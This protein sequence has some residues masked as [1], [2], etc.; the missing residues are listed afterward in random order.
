MKSSICC[1]TMFSIVGHPA[2]ICIEGETIM[3]KKILGLLL[4]LCL[5][6]G[7]LPIMAIAETTSA[8]VTLWGTAVTV[9]TDDATTDVPAAY[10]WTNGAE[11]ATPVAATAADAWNYAFT[12][13]D[14]VP[15][16]TLKNA[17]F[18]SASTFLSATFDGKL[19]VKFE[20]TNNL[21]VTGKY[22]IYY[23]SST[24]SAGKGNLFI[25]GAADATLNITGG[26]SGG[27]FLSTGKKE[28]VTISGG[29]INMEKTKAGGVNPL[30][31]MPYSKTLVENCT[32]NV[33]M[34]D[35]VGGKHPAVVM[36]YNTYGVTINN[37]NVTIETNAH[38]GF[39]MGVFQSNMTGIIYDA[40]LTITGDSNIK[41]INNANSTSSYAYNGVGLYAKTVTVKGGNLEVE[42]KK[43]AVYTT[44]EAGPNLS[45]YAGTCEMYTEKGG[46]AVTAYTATP[47]F[48]VKFVS[49]AIPST[50][51]TAPA[52]T[53]VTTPTTPSIPTAPTTPDP[54]PQ[55][56]TLKIYGDSYT[57]T[58]YDTPIYLVNGT[59]NGFYKGSDDTA[60]TKAY[61][62]QVKTG[63]TADNYNAK[64]VWNTGD[65]G[66]TLYLRDFIVDEYVEGCGWR[67]GAENLKNA[68]AV[69]G[70]HTGTAAPL[71]IVIERGECYMR[72]YDGLHYQN[73]LTIES[74]GDA[75]LTLYTLRTGILPTNV[76]AGYANTNT[77]LSGCKL[78]LDANLTV[79]MGSW[80]NMDN[81]SHVI[82]TI[83]ADLIINGGKIITENRGLSGKSCRGIGVVNSGNLYVNGGYVYSE[84]YNATNNT[85]AA[86]EAA[87]NIYI[88]G[89][90]VDVYSANQSGLRGTNIYITGGTVKARV[91]LAP[92][93]VGAETGEISFTGGVIDA[94]GAY[95]FRYN[96]DTKSQATKEPVLGT[97]L[98]G[99]VG[100]NPYVVEAYTDTFKKYVKIGYT[101][102]EKNEVPVPTPG[103]DILL[104][105]NVSFGTLKLDL[106]KYDEP[107]YTINSSIETTDAAGNPFTRWVQTTK[108]ANADNWNAMFI[109]KSTDAEPTLYLRGFKLDD[110]NN[111]ASKFAVNPNN[112]NGYYQT[113]SITTGSD[114]PLTI[115]LTG[116]DSMIECQ[117]G[118]TYN[119]NLT[120]KSEGNTKLTM[121]NQSS[122]ISPNKAAGFTL[123]IDANLVITIR[124]FYNTE[125][126]SGC[127]MNYQGDIII[128]GG[129]I[130]CNAK[131]QNKK[132]VN[133]IVAR[134][135]GNI[136]ING[137]TIT[138][139][140]TV[141]QSHANGVIQTKDKLIINGGT[142]NVQPNSAVGLHA[143]KAIE[144]NG[145]TINVISP[146]YAITTGTTA[147]PGEVI[148]NGGTL[149]VLAERCFYGNTKITIGDGV[150]AY[151]GPNEKDAELYDGSDTKLIQ[152]PWWLSTD[153]DSITIETKPATTIPTIPSF[154]QP[155]T[156]ATT[157]TGSATEPTGGATT[158]PTG[159]T[160]TT[161]T[162][163]ASTGNGEDGGDSTTTILIVA[164]IAVVVLCAGAVTFIIIKRKKA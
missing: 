12:I 17:N 118:I 70:F 7:L 150:R 158:E 38:T 92:L 72:T 6:V 106:K 69:A 108:G 146:W 115:I 102:I 97:G 131:D 81:G 98:Q 53:P 163:G 55:N 30:I 103:G 154:T 41:V 59:K 62:T 126:A 160:A 39:C 34:T 42:G 61:K 134:S 47:Y 110:W 68:A 125:F 28:Y 10:Y 94:L 93:L 109:W 63:A 83:G 37:A 49:A 117:F 151:A 132:N 87:G 100:L 54:K 46:A 113:Y 153:D 13:V 40:T 124:S 23:R 64:L 66:P 4:A 14:G 57:L 164:I 114:I 95:P 105:A 140:S 149:K 128:N 18:V 123:T 1:V 58:D 9:D 77:H 155:S 143:G 2:K 88:T 116:E 141:G 139:N 84:S 15:T 145:G 159:T 78:T 104:K 162:G 43:Q 8:T 82:R 101:T 22:A 86:I 127:I 45:A 65:N 107:I 156:P 24:N 121:N 32:L 73:D 152:R 96:P 120:I 130:K 19:K 136:I 147:A 21:N 29:T 48:K 135:S 52:T 33:K 50:P 91:S 161:P 44:A 79:S 138:G 89:G 26:N 122:G 71:K 90:T 80:V 133:T 157:P 137:G 142:I 25:E 75:S 11:G 85:E 74:V 20:G 27:S 35:G 67:Y 76:S 5:I 3:S 144:I 112:P 51:P 16:V 111:D 129:T 99:W 119:Q 60:V 31:S 56:Y 36:G 148:I